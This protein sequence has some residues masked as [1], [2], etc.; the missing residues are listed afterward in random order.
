MLTHLYIIIFYSNSIR[1]NK[2]SK[3]YINRFLNGS[4]FFGNFVRISE[5][6]SIVR[7]KKVMEIW[8]KK[9]HLTKRKKYLKRPAV[10]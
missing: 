4:I 5:L 6:I 7:N 1:N 9:L 10:F 8:I 2:N 3:E